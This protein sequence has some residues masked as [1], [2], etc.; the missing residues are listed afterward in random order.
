MNWLDLVLFLILL[1]STASAARKGFSR[2]VVGIAA[3]LIGLILGIWFYGLAG[4]FLLPY[5]SSPQVANFIGFFIVFTGCVILGSI[6]SAIIR[7]FM[8]TVGLSWFDRLLGA[9]FGLVRGT[10]MG[11]AVITALVAFAPAVAANSA[12]AA[13]AESRVAPYVLAGASFL[14]AIAPR[15][16][17]DGFHVH[18]EQLKSFWEQHKKIE[19]PKRQDPS[20]ENH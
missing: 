6:T 9:V 13:V 20:H 2:E 10:L 14:I 16:M 7:R 5:V 15:E 8:K 17:K 1:L 19:L 11:L 3:A 12:P 18:Y 4:S